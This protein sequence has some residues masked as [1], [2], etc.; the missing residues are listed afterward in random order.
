MNQETTKR[1]AVKAPQS[2]PPSRDAIPYRQIFGGAA[3]LLAAMLLIVI[4]PR[5]VQLHTQAAT[6]TAAAQATATATLA[7]TSTPAPL[8]AAQAWG[9]A[10]SQHTLALA[11]GTTFTPTDIAPDGSLLVGYALGQANAPYFIDAVALPSFTAQRLFTLTADATRPLVKT[12]GKFAAWIGGD[13]PTSGG[14]VHQTIGYINLGNGTYNELYDSFTLQYNPT[15]FA[16]I[17]GKF[18]WSPVKA[19][20]TLNATDMTTGNVAPVSLPAQSDSAITSLQPAGALLLYTLADGSLNFF[21]MATG[22]D[23]PIIATHL[24]GTT[25][26]L[27]VAD[28]ILYWAHP[29]TPA[30][31]TLVESFSPIPGPSLVRQTVVT[32]QAAHL[33]ALSASTR[34]LAWDDGQTRT[35]FDLTH[36]T[37]VLLGPSVAIMPLQLQ[38]R[39]N[40]LW[41]LTTSNGQP[42]I[43][44]VQLAQLPA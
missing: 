25:D 18:I 3:A 32:I 34:L 6:T 31:T 20:A 44:W 16:V 15:A 10:L 21:D 30:A 24:T 8:T 5:V 4:F 42:A 37:T 9:G 11:D 23:T 27:T 14:A 2:P 33:T 12:D 29:E 13:T 1:G 26:V 39:G 36:R 28:N 38:Q 17:N 40:V 41:Y 19:P 35:A 43:A 22:H 7:P